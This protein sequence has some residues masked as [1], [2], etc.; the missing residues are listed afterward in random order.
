M[1]RNEL[2]LVYG[3][4]PKRMAY[5]LADEAGLDQL[6]GDRQRRVGLKPNLVLASPAENGA[7][8]HPGLVEGLIDYLQERG[9]SKLCILEGSWVGARTREAFRLC[10]YEELSARTGVPLLDTQA[11][12]AREYDCQGLPIRICDSAMALDFLINL[13]VI[14]GHCQTYLTCALKNLKGLVPNAEKRRFHSLGL[15][16]P[17]AHLNA[18]LRQD[19]ILADG[20]CGDLNFEEGGNPVPAGRALAGRD[21]VLLDSYACSLLGLALSEVPYISLAQSLGVGCADLAQA[22]LRE[23]NR[24]EALPPAQRQGR[25]VRQLARKVCAKEACSACYAALIHALEKLD[26]EGALARLPDPLC[27]GQGFRGQSDRAGVG[28][29]N[30]C[31]GFARKLPGCPPTA[32]QIRDFL[33]GL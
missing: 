14:K 27:I 28:I 16:K 33:R 4:D 31:A 24:P 23:L 22:V 20:I 9:F 12:G 8:T 10:G 1:E 17:I 5:R 29:G 2:L 25:L 32:L 19:F 7:T 21:P 15:H 3:Q 30:C 13:P 18:K 26:G 11:D 6:I